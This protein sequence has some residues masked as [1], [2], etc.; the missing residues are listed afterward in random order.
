M[1]GKATL[2]LDDGQQIELDVIEGTEGEK[3]INI[4]PL[5]GKTG[6]ITHDP[7]YLNTGACT[8]TITFIDGEKG[9]LHYRG[10]PIE[11]LA[12]QSS[13][14]E[15]AYLLV[16]G[17]LPTKTQ[18]DAFVERI[19]NH[20]LLNER[21]KN[22]FNGFPQDAHPMAILSSMTCALSTYYP[23]ALDPLNP[24]HVELSTIRLLAK[25]PT[26]AAYSYKASRGE[27]FIYPDNSKGYTA[28]FLKMMFGYPTTGYEVDE[29]VAQILDVL[30]ILHA[31]HEQNCSTT[32]TRVVGSSRANLFA[33]VSA[34][35]NALWGPL[36]G[37]ANQEVLEML[38]VIVK[39]GNDIDKYVRLAQD[40]DSSFRLM[41]FGH[42]VYKNYDPRARILG[43]MAEKV[44][45]KLN[46]PD[47]LLDVARKLEERALNDSYFKDRKL[48]PNVDFYSGIIYRALGIPVNMFTVMFALGRLPGWI[49]QWKE[50]HESN[51]PIGRPR[52]IYTGNVNQT[53]VP[54]NQR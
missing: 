46:R 12:T 38:D 2:I 53:Y 5:R 31:D 3:A 4:K 16:N 48:Y 20:T 42:R 10:Y 6:Y 21:L 9:I 19:T 22:M 50:N 39:D 40:K 43:G 35:I 18:Y 24:E 7:G 23:D 1:A 36:H 44:L 30:L 17:V 37:G 27:P 14:L 8:S 34:G 15:V 41:G 28:N 52:Q 45:S 29:E 33:S 51:I 25:M 54:M 13:F 47:P 11:Q 26:I 49:A 32:T